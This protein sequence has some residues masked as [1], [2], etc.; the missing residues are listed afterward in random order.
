[1]TKIEENLSLTKSKELLRKKNV[2]KNPK[3]AG[4][5]NNKPCFSS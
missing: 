4:I 2:S 1:M 3:L 5:Q